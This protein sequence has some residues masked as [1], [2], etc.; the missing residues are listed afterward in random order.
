M[1]TISVIAALAFISKVN[2]QGF[3]KRCIKEI[4]KDKLFGAS[5]K[6]GSVAKSD[7]K[8]L[9]DG[10]GSIT[11]KHRVSVIKIC[12]DKD[13]VVERLQTAL[14]IPDLAN[15]KWTDRIA[16]NSFGPSRGRCGTLKLQPGEYVTNLNTKWDIKNGITGISIFTDQG[17]FLTIGKHTEVHHSHEFEFTKETQL[18]GLHGI[19]STK[20]ND[21]NLERLGVLEIDVACALGERS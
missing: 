12:K 4:P 11:N 19:I 21:Q 3:N 16:L 18:I 2:G 5:I 9:I 8:T 15:K 20:D 7:Y 13:G 1:K 17:Y 14:G 10:Q 6:K